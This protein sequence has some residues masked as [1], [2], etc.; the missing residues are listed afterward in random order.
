MLLSYVSIELTLLITAVLA[1]G[2]PIWTLACVFSDMNFEVIIAERR[3]GAVRPRTL[4]MLNYTSSTRV[5]GESSVACIH[6]ITLV[7]L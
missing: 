3:V 2:A 4:K 6:A 5:S 7:A 1:V